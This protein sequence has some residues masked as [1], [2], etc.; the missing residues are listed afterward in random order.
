MTICLYCDRDKSEDEMTLEHV[1]PQSLGG[2]Y[3]PDMYKLR[4]V[5]EKCNNDLGLF[6]D[7]GFEK[8]WLVSNVLRLSALASFDSEHPKSL[9]LICMGNS[10]LEIP[11][12]G[13]DEVCESWL[14]ALGEQIYWIRPKDEK[15]YWY[16]GGNPRTTKDKPTRA[17]FMFSTRS[18]KC[19]ILSWLSFRDAFDGKK[20][21]KKIMCTPVEGADPKD[22][23]FQAA[24]ALDERRVEFFKSNTFKKNSLG[25]TLSFFVNF[26]VRFASKLAL[27]L[28][29]SLFGE[30]FIK[31]PYITE[32]RKGLWYKPGDDLPEING[33]SVYAENQDANARK[34]MGYEHGVSLIIT[35]IGGVVT[36]SLNI[37]TSTSFDIVFARSDT[38]KSCDLEKIRDGVV[39]VLFQY[40]QKGFYLTLPQYISHKIG[41]YKHAGLVEIDKQIEKNL[42]YIR[43]L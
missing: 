19:P 27:G 36:A 40:F 23:G 35:P 29:F 16:S 5:C 22:I 10:R 13:E 12:L 4:N 25:N 14:G 21:V 18:M 8:H 26:D 37:G 38:V 31:S 33:Q 7:A 42:R 41:R 17:Y 11:G 34:L 20:K 43:E 6:V 39:I 28:G 32:L 9:P 3:A 1:L 2:A 15:L 24:D 30:D